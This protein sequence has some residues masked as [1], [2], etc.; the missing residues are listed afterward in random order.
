MTI[1]RQKSADKINGIVRKLVK[2]Y[3]NVQ[4]FY[5]NFKKE[6]GINFSVAKAKSLGMYRQEYCGCEYSIHDPKLD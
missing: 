6:G 5:S 2:A 1:S 3:P 4:Y